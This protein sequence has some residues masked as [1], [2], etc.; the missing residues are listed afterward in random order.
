MFERKNPPK[1]AKY[2]FLRQFIVKKPPEFY[3]PQQL[4]RYT[5]KPS[6]INRKYTKKN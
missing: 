3:N 6:V 2:L 1:H 4:C 5:Q